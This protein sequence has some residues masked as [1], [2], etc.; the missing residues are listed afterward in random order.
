VTDHRILAQPPQLGGSTQNWP[1]AAT[2]V[3]ELADYITR[4]KI[5]QDRIRE[6]TDEADAIKAAVQEA[7]GDYEV[8]TVHGLPVV[9]WT[10]HIRHSL[11][12][13]ALKTEAGEVYVRYLKA[14]PVRR[15]TV[16]ENPD[17]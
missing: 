9:T 4:L 7:L 1:E 17:E 16:L 5:V 12:Q 13:K 14:T 6:L 10:H 8:G 2:P 3:D 11:D 15:F